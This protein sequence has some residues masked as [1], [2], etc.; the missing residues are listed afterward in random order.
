LVYAPLLDQ[1][2]GVNSVS[3]LNGDFKAGAPA[4]F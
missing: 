1:W 2:L 4:I 3:I